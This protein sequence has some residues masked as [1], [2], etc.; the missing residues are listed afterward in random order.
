MHGPKKLLKIYK[1]RGKHDVWK[2]FELGSSSHYNRKSTNTWG[3]KKIDKPG[4]MKNK[5]VHS[6]R[7]LIQKICLW[8]AIDKLF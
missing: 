4:Q 7:M 8:E 2:I 1:C 6:I 5:F 3:F